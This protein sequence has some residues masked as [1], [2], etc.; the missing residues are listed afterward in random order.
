MMAMKR[1]FAVFFA[2]AL[3]CSAQTKFPDTPAAH[4]FSAWLDAFNSGDRAVL[5]EYLQKNNPSHAADI[6]QEFGFRNQTGGF[7]FKKVEESAP[8][9]LTGVVKER[10]SDQFARFTIEVEPAEPHRIKELDLR[11]IPPP[12][13]FPMPRMSQDAA[14]AALRAE[15]EKAAAADRFSGAV[16]IAKDGKPVLTA[17]YGLA[18]R[19]KKIPN[20]LDTRFR[21]GSMNKMFTAVSA[22]QLVQA[23]KIKLTDPLGKYLTDYPNQDVASKVTIHHLLTHS[24]GTGDFFGPQFDAHR[25]E[26]RNLQD[27]VKLYGQRGLEFE[28]GSRWAYSNYGFLLL[29]VLIERVSGQKLLRLRS[30]ACVQTRRDDFHGFA[31]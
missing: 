24:G 31:F 15:V 8:T 29:G 14:L 16:L 20:K 9:R 25:L 19:E 6:D 30:R 2:A 11:A 28:P 7:D 18:D 4:Q 3:L 10:G 12:A 27:Y 23:G 1:L 26:L 5:L 17:A 22:L 21:L 13:E